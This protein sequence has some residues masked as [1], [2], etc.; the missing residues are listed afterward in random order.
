MREPINGP[1]LGVMIVD[2]PEEAIALANDSEYRLGASVWTADRYR[3]RRIAGE[4][5]AGM[6]WC[7]DHLPSP[8]VSQGP[9]GAAAGGGLGRTLGQ[10]GLRACAQEKLITWDP[11]GPRGLWWGPYGDSLA[12]A[13]RSFAAAAL[14]A[15]LRPL[16][17]LAS[18]G[19]RHGAAGRTR[20]RP[21]VSSSQP[22]IVARRPLRPRAPRKPGAGAAEAAAPARGAC[23]R[24]RH[25]AP[26]R[27][28]G[29]SPGGTAL[30]APPAAG[31]R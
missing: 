20:R 30:A 9:W 19:S 25:A 28:R 15:R 29:P 12:R 7:N 11:P 26:A 31:R 13:A 27:A 4:L 23:T 5:R 18:R 3:A 22:P 14:G 24:R 21:P 17:R 10:A 8:A 2:S 1:V 16:A 6:V